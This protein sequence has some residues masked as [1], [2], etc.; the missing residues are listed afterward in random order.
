MSKW[1]RTLDIKD[2][3]EKASNR[4]VIPQFLASTITK[5]L[6]KLKTFNNQYIDYDK[7]ELIL[8]FQDASEDNTLTWDKLDYLL[9]DLYDWGDIS[10]DEGFGCKKVCWIKTLI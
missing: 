9:N 2:V 10:L 8:N 4:E 7:E 3:W 5:K 6:E 1:Q